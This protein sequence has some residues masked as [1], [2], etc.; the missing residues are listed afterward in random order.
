M[1]NALGGWG[2][3]KQL[4]VEVCV[5]HAWVEFEDEAGPRTPGRA[6]LELLP[7]LRCPFTWCWRYSSGELWQGDATPWK[8]SFK[9]YEGPGATE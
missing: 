8:K 4:G 2:T 9:F 5:C 6:R 7:R 1:N 3:P